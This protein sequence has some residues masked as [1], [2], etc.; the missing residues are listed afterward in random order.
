MSRCED[1]E[2]GIKILTD[3]IDTIF[4]YFNFTYKNDTGSYFYQL[5]TITMQGKILILFIALVAVT[6]AYNKG[7]PHPLEA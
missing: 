6:S 3:L 4:K 7:C 2:L 1:D 5:K